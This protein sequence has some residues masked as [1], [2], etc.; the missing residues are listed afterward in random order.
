[1]PISDTLCRACKWREKPS[2][3]NDG[4]GLCSKSGLHS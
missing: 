2:K 1:M 3:L 4:G